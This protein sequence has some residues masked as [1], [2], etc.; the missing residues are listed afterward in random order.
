MVWSGDQ[1]TKRQL[2]QICT[3]RSLQSSTE[4]EAK[5]EAKVI[6][7]T[8]WDVSG[9]LPGGSRCILISEERDVTD[10]PTVPRGPQ[11]AGGAEPVKVPGFDPKIW[12]FRV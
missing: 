10:M 5:T 4:P 2:L 12:G 9:G 3:L 11:R 6:E 1:A 8:K 7:G